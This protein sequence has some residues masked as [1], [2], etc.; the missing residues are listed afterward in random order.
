MPNPHTKVIPYAFQSL[1]RDNRLGNSLRLRASSEYR[2]AFNR[3][4]ARRFG[5]TTWA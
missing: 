3:P 1:L 4:R 2:P 5:N